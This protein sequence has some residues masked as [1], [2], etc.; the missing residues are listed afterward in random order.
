MP[1][2]WRGRSCSAIASFGSMP[3]AI[4]TD[5]NGVFSPSA[6]VASSSA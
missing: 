2:N 6:T 5:W 1:G 4:V 3:L